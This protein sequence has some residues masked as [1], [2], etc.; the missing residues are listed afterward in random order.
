MRSRPQ[1][2]S[3]DNMIKFREP[4]QWLTGRETV[5]AI[6][7]R[8]KPSAEEIQ[9]GIVTP[10]RGIGVGC[11]LLAR[12]E[13]PAAAR[14]YLAGTLLPLVTTESGEPIN[15]CYLNVAFTSHGRRGAVSHT[16]TLSPSVLNE[17]RAQGPIATRRSNR[18]I[19]CAAAGAMAWTKADPHWRSQALR[20]L[21]VS[22]FCHSRGRPFA[23]KCSTRSACNVAATC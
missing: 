20:A 1:T 16:V 9:G 13:N 5:P 22:D 8:P 12:I 11:V 23:T 21:G 7:M 4:L 2:F 6:V 14:K 17:L 15:D 10:F 19:Q 18:S 3:P